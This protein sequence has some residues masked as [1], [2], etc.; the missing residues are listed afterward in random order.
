M[1]AGGQTDMTKLVV[2]FFAILQKRLMKT[3][4]VVHDVRHTEGREVKLLS[5]L[6]S[7]LDEEVINQLLVLAAYI[8]HYKPAA[9]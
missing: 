1:R 9:H 3:M 2:A 4:M 7:I 6:A 5:F 8:R